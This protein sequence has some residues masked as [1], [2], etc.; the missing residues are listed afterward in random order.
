MNY[1]YYNPLSGNGHGKETAKEAEKKFGGELVSV[2]DKMPG[3]LI[4]VLKE[5]DVLILCGGDGTVNRFAN[6]IAG[7][8]LPCEVLL[9]KSGTGND[10]IRDLEENYGFNETASVKKFITNLPKV[11]VKGMECHFI[12]GIGF[13]L[14]GVCCEIADEQKE[15]GI[16]KINYT[17]IAIKLLLFGFRCPSAKVTIDGVTKEF[18]RVWLASS[19]NGRYYGGGMKN[20][21]F[22]DRL[23]DKLTCVIWHDSGKIATLMNFPNIFKGVHIKKEKKVFVCE[24]K[25]IKVEFSHPSSLQIDGETITGVTEYTAF[26]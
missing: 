14:D 19:M 21:P 6:S 5:E 16:E 22:Q 1:I 20:A 4:S 7:M 23:S 17:G 8:E 25:E 11:K 12:N 18:K 24:G 10:F 2:L 15:K 3:E 13:G 9:Y 26:K